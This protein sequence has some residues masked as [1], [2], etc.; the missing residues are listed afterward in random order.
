MVKGF[1]PKNLTKLYEP[2]QVEPLFSQE[3]I[4][5]QEKLLTNEEILQKELANIK[6]K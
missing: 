1:S 4:I 2:E 3:K 5:D 6:G